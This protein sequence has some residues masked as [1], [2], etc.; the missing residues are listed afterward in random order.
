MKS[1]NLGCELHGNEDKI[2]CAKDGTKSVFDVKIKTLEGTLFAAK[3]QRTATEVRGAVMQQKT[4]SIKG[5]HELLGHMDEAAMQK[6]AA[7]LGWTITQGTLGVCESCAEAKAKQI[8]LA[9]EEASKEKAKEVNGRV[10][11]DSSHM[12]NPNTEKQPRQPNWCLIVD[13]KTGHKSSSFH[14]T[15][16]GMVD[17]MHSKFKNW[18]DNS[19]EVKIVHMDNGGENKKLVKNS[20]AKAGNCIQKLNAQPETCHST[21]TLWKWA[22]PHSMGEVVH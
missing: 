7:N 2:W 9:N 11:L 13:E 20:T 10:H 18:K 19:E 5:A 6:A 21:I 1:L 17:P 22:L 16:D 4:V 14:K 8:N 12:F 3:L 15:K